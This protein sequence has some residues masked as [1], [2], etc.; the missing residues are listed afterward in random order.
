M[1]RCTQTLYNYVKLLKTQ[2]EKMQERFKQ[3]EKDQ[4]EKYPKD[5]MV[6]QNR[7]HQ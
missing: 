2:D 1:K 6:K 3:L 4:Q 7:N 5:N